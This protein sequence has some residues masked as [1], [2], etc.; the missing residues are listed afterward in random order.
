MATAKMKILEDPLVWRDLQAFEE[1]VAN[2]LTKQDCRANVLRYSLD[3]RDNWFVIDVVG[4]EVSVTIDSG[5]YVK[6]YKN[7]Q[8]AKQAKHKMMAELKHKAATHMERI[9]KKWE[10]S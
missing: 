7:K 3:K 4:E 8:A 5:T 10:R 2:S 6:Q 1:P 9:L